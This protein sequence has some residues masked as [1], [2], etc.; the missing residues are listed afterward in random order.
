MLLRVLSSIDQKLKA[1]AKEREDRKKFEI[2]QAP[3]LE[4]TSHLR[5][6]GNLKLREE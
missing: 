2:K 1:S 5:A 4:G 3:K 6:K